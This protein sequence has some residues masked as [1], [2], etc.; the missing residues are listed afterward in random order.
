[1]IIKVELFGIKER[2]DCQMKSA[3][4]TSCSVAVLVHSLEDNILY[5]KDNLRKWPGCYFGD[6]LKDSSKCV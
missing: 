4:V 1:M 3:V 2:F 6:Y 5:P